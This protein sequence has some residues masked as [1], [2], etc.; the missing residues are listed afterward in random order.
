VT[1]DLVGRFRPTGARRAAWNELVTY[2]AAN[3]YTDATKA[4]EGTF[5]RTGL[6]PSRTLELVRRVI[7]DSTAYS[8][9]G[10]ILIGASPQFVTH[11][12]H[13]QLNALGILL[14]VNQLDRRG[15]PPDDELS[16]LD[17]GLERARIVCLLNNPARLGKNPGRDETDNPFDRDACLRL[18]PS[19]AME[20]AHPSD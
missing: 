18:L 17:H 2:T 15:K 5:S 8:A 10:H 1:L 19:L 13:A 12:L 20:L 3:A 16:W 6:N 9:E 7:P 14:H 4:Q 11:L